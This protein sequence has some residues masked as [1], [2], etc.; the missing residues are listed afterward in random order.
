MAFAIPV[1][2]PCSAI[3]VAVAV[4]PFSSAAHAAVPC[5]PWRPASASAPA[6]T[7][8]S[9]PAPAQPHVHDLPA[10]AHRHNS[11]SKQYDFCNGYLLRRAEALRSLE[12]LRGICPGRGLKSGGRAAGRAV[13]ATEVRGPSAEGVCVASSSCS[14]AGSTSS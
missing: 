8:A 11:S 14:G 6:P 5:P 2:I 4:G 10:T 13:T 1:S 9:T 7:K 12:R 3:P